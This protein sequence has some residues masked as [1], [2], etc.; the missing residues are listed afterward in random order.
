MQ[1]DGS[2]KKVSWKDQ[3]CVYVIM[4]PSRKT[5][6]TYSIIRRLPQGLEN[7]K[8]TLLALGYKEE[9]LVI[10]EMPKPWMPPKKNK[11]KHVGKRG[12]SKT[13]PVSLVPTPRASEFSGMIH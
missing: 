1:K 8:K 7:V 3:D 9:E 13:K 2:T 12:R 5:G 11:R 6:G 4:Y 10:T